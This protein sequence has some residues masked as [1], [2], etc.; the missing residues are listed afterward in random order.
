[1]LEYKRIR[2]PEHPNADSN[3]CVLVHRLVWEEHNN[4]MLLCWVDVHHINGNIH[5]NRIDNLE[6]IFHDEHARQHKYKDMENRFCSICNRKTTY[7]TR[8]RPDWRIIN[9]KYICGRC[10]KKIWNSRR[11]R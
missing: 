1:L 9:E 4:A 6:A 5:D 11:V 10:Y 7:Q 8:G 2:K 3:G